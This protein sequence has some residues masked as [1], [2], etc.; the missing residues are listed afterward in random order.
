MP[1]PSVR[2]T[3]AFILLGPIVAFAQT[4]RLDVAVERADGAPVVSARVQLR[5]SG[6]GFKADTLTN[7]QGRARFS[8][9]P[10]AANYSVL[11]EGVQ[12]ADSLRLR[13]NESQS[14]TLSQPDTATV[15]ITAHRAAS[16]GA[17]DAEVSG[18]LT[19]AAL[20][21]LPIEARDLNRALVRLPNVVPSTG[22]FPEAPPVSIN[23]ANG[24]S[25]QYLIDGLD[26][27]ENFLG[28][29][30]FPVST[31]FVQDV[32]VLSSSYSVEYGRTGNG[33]VNVTSKSGS[34][35]WTGEA[36]YLLRPGPSLDAASAYPN[37]DLT[38]NP[39]KAG[40]RRE[41]GGFG[42]GGPLATDRTFLYANLEYARDRK[43]NLLLS[44]DLGIAATVPGKNTQLLASFKLDQRLGDVWRLALRANRGDV[45]IGRQGGDLNGGVTFPSAGS[46]EDRISSLLALSATYD[47]KGFTSESNVAYGG[48]HWN[49]T[50]AASGPGP[51]VTLLGS[52]GLPVAV[53]GNPGST[54]DEKENSL[55]FKQKFAW[56]HGIHLFKIGADLLRSSF[57]LIGGGNPD[58]NFTVRLSPS[59]IAT[60]A[61]LRRG[62]SLGVSDVPT[63]AQVS[64]YEVELRPEAFGRVQTQGALYAEDQLSLSSALTLTGGLRWDYDTLT[65]AGSRRA[66]RG[67][68]APRLALNYRV[69]SDLS[70][71]TGAGL[72]Y[73]KLP[74]TV[75]SDALQ[76]N[77]T[78]P[79]YRAQLAQL[80]SDGLLPANTNLAQVTFAGNSLVAPACPLGY[81]RCP[82]PTA[83]LATVAPAN[84]RRILSPQGLRSPYTFQ[85]SAGMQ[86]QPTDSAV[87]SADLILALG[88]HLVRLRDVNA[89]ALFYPNLAALT[90]ANVS[91]L[92]SVSDPVARA[93]LAE[94]L[95]L[96]RSQAAADA[97][98]PASPVAGGAR[99]IV[100]TETAG[101]SRYAALN[102][103]LR[104][105]RAGRWYGYRLSYTL[106]KLENDT[107]DINFR[108]S[109]PNDFAAEWGP[110]INDRRH[111]IS[112]ILY[113]YPSQDLVVTAAMLLQSG[114]PINY[115]PDARIYGTTDLN[116][117]GASFSD[118][119]LGNAT[120]AP[121]IGRNTGRL[122]W[123]RTVDLGLRYRPRFGVGRIEVSAD[124]FN[125]LNS[126]N[127]SGFANAATQSNQIQVYGEPFM[128]RNAGPARQFQFGVRYA[129]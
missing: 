23:G 44:P 19:A 123:S 69:R 108:A 42:I 95:G 89:P 124:V 29:P 64:D 4:A 3:A 80:A 110:S 72:Y 9:V 43:D 88:R 15:T 2:S 55:Q 106:S 97:T 98:R 31:G 12:L 70:V 1:A 27:N 76:Q 121:G 122:P 96:V 62:A 51:Q 81:M 26:N 93:A 99:Q 57:S 107:D 58:G 20:D 94:T 17:L 33:I 71:R 47:V 87:A 65:K 79:A 118:A 105:E 48:F 24:L 34:N 25:A 77:A 39:V 66:E 84:E 21:V 75:L 37:R 53:L 41:Q 46:Q 11:V 100:L 35:E 28:G 82:A 78:T 104:N 6:S 54:F 127:L 116:G 128:A 22:F 111:V 5:N 14:V 120:R 90:P 74:Y 125:V 45:A 59:E 92:R 60:L 52:S 8:A 18:T 126:V 114:Q 36:F 102:L 119:Y 109:N 86:W 10:A 73:E 103:A 63:G 113:L 38:G 30:K 101:N 61:A 40:F 85:W 56:A 68:V 67:D 50:R 115:I 91:L 49:Y 117:N 83:A 16:A 7:Q 32:T 129:F 112:G 13:A